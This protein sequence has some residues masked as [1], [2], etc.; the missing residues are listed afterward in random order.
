MIGRAIQG[1]G[2]GVKPPVAYVAVGRAYP[3]D[4][5]ARIFALFATAWVVPGLVGP[6]L[7]GVTAEFLTWRLVFLAILPLVGMAALLAL[8]ALRAI[9]PPAGVLPA[10]DRS[11]LPLALLLIALSVRTI[12]AA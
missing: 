9:G 5:R 7:A 8:P 2:G 4:A 12:L 11:R 10:L 3:E 6:G 1:L